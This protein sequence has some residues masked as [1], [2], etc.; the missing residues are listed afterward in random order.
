[1]T[2]TED[3]TRSIRVDQFLAHPPARVWHALTDPDMM[4]R[5]WA[6]GDIKPEVGHRFHLDMD[7]WGHV[8]CMVLAVEPERRLV[9]T[10]N[11]TWTLDWTLVAEGHGTRL[12]LEHRG[13]D[14]D[15]PRD[16][17]A[18]ERM[19]PGWRDEVLPDLARALDQTAV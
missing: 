3:R 19:G 10:F 13:F 12:L 14:L 1:M 5:W 17:Y 9:F 11:E 4:E 18:L 2:H 8:P 15:N 7:S 6:A 16:R